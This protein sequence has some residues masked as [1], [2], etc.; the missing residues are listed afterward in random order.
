MRAKKHLSQN[1]LYDP[2][3]LGRI[4]DAAGVT[5]DDTVLEIGPGPG[6]LT[7]VLLEHAREV[8]AVEFDSDLAARNEFSIVHCQSRDPPR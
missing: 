7:D 1:F 6:A 5:P 8:I 3:I 2:M 4:V